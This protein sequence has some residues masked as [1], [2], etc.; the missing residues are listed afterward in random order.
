VCGRVQVQQLPIYGSTS[1]VTTQNHSKTADKNMKTIKAAQKLT[2]VYIKNES[3][4]Q[5][6]VKILRSPRNSIKSVSDSGDVLLC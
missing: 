5:G 3:A 1:S 2:E 6:S 4:R